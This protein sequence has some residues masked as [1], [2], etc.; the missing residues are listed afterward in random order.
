LAALQKI[1]SMINRS[2]NLKQ[3]LEAALEEIMSAFGWEAGAFL[4]VESPDAPSKPAIY[5]GFSKNVI[6]ILEE[7]QKSS[8]ALR[9]LERD[10]ALVV[11][12]TRDS[13][14]A[15]PWLKVL[16]KKGLH[17]FMLQPV[18]TGTR[19]LGTIELASVKRKHPRQPQLDFLHTLAEILAVAIADA[20]LK[21]QAGKLSE[22]LVA[23]QEVNKIISQSFD[24]QDI[25]RRI[26]AEGKRLVKTSHCHLFLIDDRSQRLVGSASTQL[27][28]A[29]VRKLQIPLSE[30]SIAITA[31]IGKRIILVGDTDQEKHHDQGA[32]PPMPWR[33]AIY[34]PLLTKDQSL[35]VLVCSDDSH[36]RRF[37][38]EQI[39]RAETLAHQ[40]SIALENARLFQVVSRSQK[41]WETTFDAMQDCVS[42]HDPN[43]KAIRANLALARRLKTIPQEVVGRY[44]GELYNPAGS[45]MVPCRHFRSMQ[46]EALIVEEVELPAMGGTFQICISPWLDKN[47]RLAGSIHVAKDISNEKLLQQ[48]LIQ[49]E[50]LSAIGELIS[51]IAHELNNPLT[52]VMGYSQLL[53]LRNDIDERAKDSLLKI[54]SLA[55]R[56]Q[57]IV[58]NLLSFARKQKPERT[59][60]NLNEVIESTIELRNYEFQVNNIEIIRDLDRN[61]VK[62]IADGHQLQQVFLN[63]ITNAEQAML[64]AHGSGRLLIRTRADSQGNRITVEIVDNGPGIPESNLIK[65]FDPF[66][67]TK[68]VGKG[69]GLGLS[70]SYGII[71]EHG[72]N[73]Y[74]SSRLGEGST[75]VIE[76]PIIVPSGAGTYLPPEPTPQS[77]HFENLVQDKR[78][79]VVDDEKYILEFFIEVFRMFPIHVDTAGDGLAAMEKIRLNDYDLIITD[80]KMPHMSGKELYGWIK[81]NRPSLAERIIFVTGDTVSTETRTFF[82]ENRSRF[83]AKPFK[84]EDV[85]DAIQQTLE[86]TAAN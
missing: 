76:L 42:V 80:F 41:E 56:C 39:F 30:P 23:L 5:K 62:T 46:S 59:L 60:I 17:T 51:G 4:F 34:A 73:I 82:E 19:V 20:H 24:Q 53:Q 55:L 65:I 74:V 78:I 40:A 54:N 31:L 6:L 81:D 22:D 68:E 69:T 83:L 84:I 38:Q 48:K 45:N 27:D 72:G 44:C 7:A 18:R 3:I 28:G 63:V 26:V 35:G 11:G 52:G 13:E 8:A 79:L 43:G 86:T 32:T 66:F 58:Q 50:K 14:G 2:C 29:E 71:K 36:E 37:T 10:K 49:S 75:F 77:L 47:N 25:I 67:T 21:E 12:N 33:A 1:S 85:M 64:E 16:Q 9:A 15:D 57:R 70:L 61:M